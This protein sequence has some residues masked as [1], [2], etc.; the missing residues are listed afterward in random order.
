MELLDVL[1]FVGSAV[2]RKDYVPILTH[3]RIQNGR[4]LGFN[5]RVAISSPIELDLV[6]SPKAVPFIKAIQ[7]ARETVQ[8]HL[9]EKQRLVI[10]SGSFTAHIECLPDGPSSEFPDIYPEGFMVDLEGSKILE[11][12]YV[13]EPFVSEDASRPW[14]QGILLRDQSAF[15]T[16]N[17]IVIQ[18]WIGG[19]YPDLNIPRET[20]K[21]ITRIKE[22][23]IKL[24]VGKTS[25]TFH[26]ESG[27][28]LRSQM[29]TNEWPDVY[30]LFEGERSDKPIPAGFFE[31]LEDLLPFI[32][33]ELERV[34]ILQGKLT[35]ALEEGTG[36]AATIEGIQ[37]GG[38]YNL[39]Q[40][41]KI[42]SVAKSL[43]L[44]SYPNPMKFFGDGLRGV[45][46]GMR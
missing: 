37:E 33:E 9:T 38:V 11:A 15:V 2:A 45:I 35:T 20:I 40:L 5:G 36:A 4:I 14:S 1:R 44:A 42:A 6:C 18:K 24:Q 41:L 7:T 26:Y 32:E 19:N 27:R 31:A 21:E 23:P 16:N 30:P 12:I 46:A 13:L 34:F 22:K 3:F 17:V 29:L 8:M 43:D 25:L 28:W 39:P 10:R